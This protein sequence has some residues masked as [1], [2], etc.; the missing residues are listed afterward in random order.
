MPAAV[1]NHRQIYAFEYVLKKRDQELEELATELKRDMA[2][3]ANR[4]TQRLKNPRGNTT[5]VA[6]RE[7]ALKKSIIK[8]LDELQ[9]L[10][11]RF[12]SIILRLHLDEIE[13]GLVLDARRQ[14]AVEYWKRLADGKVYAGA[15]AFLDILESHHGIDA[16]AL[17][18]LN[19]TETHQINATIQKIL[20]KKRSG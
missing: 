4:I 16:T 17:A 9:V 12:A 5:S 3:G 1:D 7:A 15:R 18:S 8:K 20:E 19:E 11:P 2:E 10:A 6:V 14:A 13:L